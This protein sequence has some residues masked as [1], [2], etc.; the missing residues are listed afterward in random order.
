[1]RPSCADTSGVEQN[2]SG[3]WQGR[4]HRPHRP[5]SRVPAAVVAAVLALVL[6][7]VL[8][9]VGVAQAARSES[10]TTSLRP[11]GDRVRVGA[12][13]DGMTADPARL[14][15][16]GTTIDHRIGLA[17]YYYGYGDV[18]PGPLERTFAA[19]GT[20]DVLLSWDMGSSRFR[21][22]A[23]GA[24][25]DYLRRIAQAA[26]AYPWRVYVRPWP[27]MNGDWQPFQPTAQ[28]GKPAG[29]TY[30]E[31]KAAWR[32]VVS[33]TRARGATNLRWVFNPS[34]DTYPGTTPV[35]RI[36]PG[37]RYVDVLGIDGFNW[38]DGGNYGGWR[39]FAT[40]FNR[41]YDALTALDSDAP[42]WI[43]E[44]GSKEPREDDGAPATTD[45]SKAAWF[46]T[47]L[48]LRSM[49]RLTALTFFQMAK[50]RDWRADSSADALKAVQDYL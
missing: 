36:W 10:R 20:R 16:F 39:S 24:H 15:E 44:F 40:V 26:R 33:Y 34:A 43:C 41:Q 2:V 7:T 22:W 17:S 27:E 49:P 5:R 42:V 3:A 8:G 21:S 1:M 25:D 29:G 6:G 31:F 11:L 50:E 47:A 48:T 30:A 28:G 37:S 38:G 32:H 18:F 4:P 46:R 35:S 14:D 19:G 12:F 23:Q 45:A 13:V 9:M